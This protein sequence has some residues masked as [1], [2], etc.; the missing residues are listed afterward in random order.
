[1]TRSAIG[2]PNARASAKQGAVLC[3]LRGDLLVHRGVCK[4]CNGNPQRREIPPI[5]LDPAESRRAAFCAACGLW[6][7]ATNRCTQ[8]RSCTA[9]YR[10]RPGS[11]CP[12]G[13]PWDSELVAIENHQSM[14]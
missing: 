8:R 10:R 13:K 6:D 14:S 3:G 5:R 12:L 1:V 11:V 4:H 2:C 9:C 7:S